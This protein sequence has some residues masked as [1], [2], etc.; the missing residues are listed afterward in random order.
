MMKG[1]KAWLHMCSL[2]PNLIA[3]GQHDDKGFADVLTYIN[4]LYKASLKLVIVLG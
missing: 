4:I 3:P 2:L 1:L